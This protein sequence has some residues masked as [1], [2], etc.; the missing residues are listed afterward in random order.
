[1]HIK[2]FESHLFS[3]GKDEFNTLS[4]C[5]SH[6]NYL[7]FSSE[8]YDYDKYKKHHHKY[9]PHVQISSL[10]HKIQESKVT[11]QITLIEPEMRWLCKGL[12]E[13]AENSLED[14]EQALED[15]S[16]KGTWALDYSKIQLNILTAFRNALNE[17][18]PDSLW[19]KYNRLNKV[20]Y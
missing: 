20:N 3:I 19:N 16:D 9:L 7:N 17:P 13:L 10:D 5:V 12:K 11:G 2:E 8:R 15:D 18:E 4:V 6:L 14:T 1:M